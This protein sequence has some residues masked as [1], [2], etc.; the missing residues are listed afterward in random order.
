M[1]DTKDLPI[2]PFVVPPL[3]FAYGALEPFFDEAT[4]RLHHDKHHRSYVDALNTAIEKYPELHGKS[5]EAI[6]GDLE[7]VPAAIRTTVR[8]Q[9][10]GHANHALYWQVIG[11]PGTQ[12]QGELRNAIETDFGSVEKFKAQFTEQAVKHFASGWAVLSADPHTCQLAVQ[13]LP[14]HES[15]LSNGRMPLLICDVWEHA[16]YLKYEN[17]RAEFVAAFWNV[18]DWDVVGARLAAFRADLQGPRSAARPVLPT[19]MQ[20]RRALPGAG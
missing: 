13:S 15:A 5:I 19:A 3:Q 4:M 6:L 8:N 16:Y 9:G 14:G 11:P 12:L 20:G 7:N 10:G 2:Y 1:R 17:R 18:V